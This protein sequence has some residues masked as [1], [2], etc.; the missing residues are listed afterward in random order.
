M[1]EGQTYGTCLGSAAVVPGIIEYV[2]DEQRKNWSH[3]Q[4]L[5]HYE[6]LK[7]ILD[8][9]SSNKFKDKMLYRFHAVGQ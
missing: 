3:H 8:S 2:K 9:Y 6:L 7:L 5:L 4:N 1:Q